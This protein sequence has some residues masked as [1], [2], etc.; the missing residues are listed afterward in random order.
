LPEVFQRLHGGSQRQ[1]AAPD[2][3][4]KCADKTDLKAEVGHDGYTIEWVYL[5]VI[6][7][8]RAA[9]NPHDRAFTL[10]GQLIARGDGTYQDVVLK[11][12]GKLASGAAFQEAVDGLPWSDNAG[13]YFYPLQTA[14]NGHFI[15]HFNVK[16]PLS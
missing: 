9:C 11:V 14:K 16:E 12:R 15:R 13:H 3:R 10:E 7:V 1:G 2:S 6:L 8:L 4:K 5:A